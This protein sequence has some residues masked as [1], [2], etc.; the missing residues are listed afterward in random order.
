MKDF[1]GYVLVGLALVFLVAT[2][3]GHRRRERFSNDSVWEKIR[4]EI[5]GKLGERVDYDLSA[6]RK[7][8]LPQN[9]FFDEMKEQLDSLGARIGVPLGA[10]DVS[11]V[12]NTEKLF[13]EKIRILTDEMQA[14]FKKPTIAN[15]TTG[16]SNA[17][18]ISIL[19]NIAKQYMLGEAAGLNPTPKTGTG[20]STSITASVGNLFS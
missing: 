17:L 3:V 9:P 18:G 10:P 15:A 5:E 11:Q 6:F 12:K 1:A 13:D 20:S 2:L 8:V 4:I 7:A 14:Q 16:Y 19:T